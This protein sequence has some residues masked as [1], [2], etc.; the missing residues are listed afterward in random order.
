MNKPAAIRTY[1]L[2]WILPILLQ[3]TASTARADGVEMAGG[4]SCQRCGAA[5]CPD[6]LC[7]RWISVPMNVTET[8]YKSCVVK[9]MEDREETY[10]VFRR[11]PVERKFYR[12]ECYLEDEVKTK[13]ITETQCHLINK[14]VERTVKVPVPEIQYREC[15]C[16]QDGGKACESCQSCEPRVCQVIVLGEQEIQE[17]CE[18]TDVVFSKTTKQIDY[19]VKVP[20]TKK[21]LCTVEKTYE[22]QPFEETRTVTVCVPKLIKTPYEVTVCRMVPQPI[23]CCAHCA[24]QIDREQARDSSPRCDRA[25][26]KHKSLDKL[27]EHFENLK[28]RDHALLGHHQ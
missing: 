11:V 26:K 20:K 4:D 19:C 13:T 22:L 9:D 1:L 10:T 25:D 17:S 18:Q 2:A 12:E 3:S 15:P 8:R 16:G 6:T 21:T 5:C 28:E 27:K 24:Q 23:L 14:P 7:S